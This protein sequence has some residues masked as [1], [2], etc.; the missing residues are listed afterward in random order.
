MLFN[1]SFFVLQPLMRVTPIRQNL[2]PILVGHLNETG[3][4]GQILADLFES[5]FGYLPGTNYFDPGLVSTLEDLF[6]HGSQIRDLEK[7]GGMAID[8]SGQIGTEDHIPVQGQSLETIGTWIGAGAQGDN[9]GHPAKAQGMI[10][11]ISSLGELGLEHG[12]GAVHEGLKAGIH[13]EIIQGRGQNGDIGLNEFG[14]KNICH[15]VGL[16][17]AARS[18]SPATETALTGHNVIVSQIDELIF[19]SGLLGSG[20]KGL[21]ELVGLAGL[22]IP[23]GAVKGYELHIDILLESSQIGAVR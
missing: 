16:T 21:K 22:G 5:G 2:A 18:L 14:K 8:F 15:I 19:C 13:G 12:Q 7:F 9:L 17:A 3:S 1:Q 23:G 6:D 11:P 20:Q 10:H 4:G